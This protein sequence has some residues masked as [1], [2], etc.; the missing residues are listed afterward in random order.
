[1]KIAI[2][3]A[4]PAGLAASIKAAQKYD[5][6][7]FEKNS[8]CGKKLLLTGNGR[9][10]LYHENIL[11]NIEKIHSE[12]AKLAQDFIY[13][14]FSKY[15]DFLNDI[16]LVLINKNGYIYPYSLKSY[17]VLAALKKAALNNK[18]KF[19]FNTEITSISK[20]K[21]K[22]IV[23][24]EEFSKVII[25]TGSLCFPKTGSDGK[26][27]T[28]AKTFNHNIIKVSP[29]LVPLI[30]D[31]KLEKDWAGKRA[32]V[33]V[34]L[35]E[36]DKKIK[37]EEGEIQFTNYGLSG[38]CIFNLSS[39][40][41]KGLDKN[42]K[43]EISINFVPWLKEDS[44]KYFEQR[45]KKFVNYTITELCDGL[46]DYKI[47]YMILKKIHLNPEKKW[48]NLTKIEKE[49]FSKSIKDFRILIK[50]TKGFNESQVCSGGI[51][52]N[53]V[54]LS[55]MESKKEKGLYFAGE[56]VDM[57]GDCGGYNLTIAFTTGLVAGE[58]ND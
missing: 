26:G 49:L 48:N 25:T 29:S 43:E 30:T 14:N 23:N 37:S 9:A 34:S 57:D 13:H 27:Y 15:Q 12:N 56:I 22:F 24:Q 39:L 16:G 19:C 52:L 35:Y 33:V 38:I 11:N 3:G 41:R 55:T 6:T 18:V 53:E 58:L 46:M 1:M 17:S 36:N 20:K 5:V 28:I 10:N 31:E 47:V 8:D 2:I 21:D 7:I 32:E 54:N 51:S 45:S 40:V 44:Y 42:F 50:D 4:G